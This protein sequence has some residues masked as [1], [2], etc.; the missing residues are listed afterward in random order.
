M[1]VAR[2]PTLRQPWRVRVTR[3]GAFW[4]LIVPMVFFAVALVLPVAYVFK[5]AITEAGWRASVDTV[6]DD[7][8]Q[9]AFVRT[10]WL[11][12]V[13]TAAC[14]S[15]GMVYSLAAAMARPRLRYFLIGT[16]LAS[17]WVSLL[18]RTYGWVVL[19][20][21]RGILF[22]VLDAVGLRDQPLDLLQT[23]AAMYPAMV[24]VMLP[25]MVLPLYAALRSVDVNQLMA[26]QSMGARPLTVFRRVV[27]PQVASGTAAGSALVFILSLGFFVTPALLGGPRN[28]TLSTL[29]DQKFRALFDFGGAAVMGL[30]L[31]AAVLVLMALA[32]RLFGVSRVWRSIL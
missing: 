15:L 2:R 1:D 11:S 16:L 26:A 31:L 27:L 20:Q 13:V 25:Y 21:P 4:L 6:T 9:A 22:K 23:S 29:I 17:F 10:L 5:T 19:F 30:V 12:A 14:W 32:E 8:F 28:L 7:V 18:V 24:H 3:R